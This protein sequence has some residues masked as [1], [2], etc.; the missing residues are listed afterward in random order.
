MMDLLYGWR[1]DHC[2]FAVVGKKWSGWR[3]ATGARSRDI[4]TRIPHQY[5][6]VR[7][8]VDIHP[9]QIHYSMP[10]GCVHI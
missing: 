1:Y 3:D 5:H 2:F 8:L 7:Y 9:L 6:K 4:V 10:H